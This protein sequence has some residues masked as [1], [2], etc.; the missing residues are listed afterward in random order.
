MHKS[1]EQI[2]QSLL[3]AFCGKCLWEHGIM[4]R[5][6]VQHVRTDVHGD[7]FIVAVSGGWSVNVFIPCDDIE[8]ATWWER[9]V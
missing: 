3:N 9:I 8:K 4:P 7:E 5:L 2:M 6:G 1:S